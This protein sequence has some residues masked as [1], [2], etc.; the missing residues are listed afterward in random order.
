MLIHSIIHINNSQS[1]LSP[2]PTR[3]GINQAVAPWKNN[4]AQAAGLG[5]GPLQERSGPTPLSVKLWK[6]CD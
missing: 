2:Y 1:L 5:F 6:T 3:K 4:K